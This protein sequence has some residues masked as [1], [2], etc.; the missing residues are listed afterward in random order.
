MECRPGCAACC[1]YPSISS[2]IPGMLGGKSAGIRCI[3]LTDDLRCALFGNPTRPKVCV[4][5]KPENLF[6][7][8]SAEDAKNILEWLMKD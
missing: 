6:C 2:S 3:Q 5:F 1:I 4:R 7:G 8:D